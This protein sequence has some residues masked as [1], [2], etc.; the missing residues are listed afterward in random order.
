MFGG[1]N[2][3][4]D[5]DKRKYVYSGY[6]I[7]F[8]GKDGRNFGNDSPRNVLIFV[9]DTSSSSHTNNRVLGEGDTLG[10]NGSFGA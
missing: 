9:V 6:G 3:G 8:Y 1:T 2:I 4:K 7:P 10:I 5:N